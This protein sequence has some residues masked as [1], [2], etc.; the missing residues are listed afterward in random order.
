MG[1]FEIN[2][3][4][5]VHLERRIASVATSFVQSKT[6]SGKVVMFFYDYV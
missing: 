4:E 5:T 2:N 1:I 6:S 3:I